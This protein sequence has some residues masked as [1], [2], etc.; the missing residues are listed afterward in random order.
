MAIARDDRW[1]T[2]ALGR[3][4]AGAQGF[5]CTQPAVTTTVPPSPLAVVYSDLTG[6]VIAQP[7]ITDGFGHSVAYLDN[8]ALYTIV[9]VHP[10]FGPYPVVLIDQAIS[11]GS[12]G[13]GASGGLPAPV[14]PTGTPNGVL[15]TF[16]LSFAPS[17]PANGQLFVSGS[18]ARYGVDYNITGA[19]IIWIGVI[20]PQIGDNLV[21]FGS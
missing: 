18:Y 4:L 15:R 11:A 2:D 8:T 17:H 12:A 20:P 13:G 19:N 10:L 1:L 3:A 6:D 7:L 16:G 14:I 21:Y 5:Y 9:F